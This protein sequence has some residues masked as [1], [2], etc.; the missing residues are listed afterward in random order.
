MT[1]RLA[2]IGAAAAAVLIV[3]IPIYSPAILAGQ[4]RP[5]TA[6]SSYNP[7]RTPDGKP[8]L[9]GVWRVWNLAK[10]DVEPHGPRRVSRPGLALSSI[11]PTG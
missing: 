8:D 4:Q 11:R 7:P 6:A 9:Q 1:H 10:Y 2:G 3:A 5:A